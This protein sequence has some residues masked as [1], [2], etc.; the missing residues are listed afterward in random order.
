M[1]IFLANYIFLSLDIEL[2]L[3]KNEENQA[4]MTTFSN[5]A[6]IYK[7]MGHLAKSLKIKERVYS[8]NPFP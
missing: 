4:I 1:K 7:T 6:M 8:R 3:F 5:I 2:K